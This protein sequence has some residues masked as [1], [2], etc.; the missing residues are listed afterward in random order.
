MTQASVHPR[1][2]L[3]TFSFLL[4]ATAAMFAYGSIVHAFRTHNVISY[5]RFWPCELCSDEMLRVENPH[6]HPNHCWNF[7]DHPGTSSWYPNPL[8]TSY[9]PR[10]KMSGVEMPY[11]TSTSFVYLVLG[12]CLVY[13]TRRKEE[14]A[15]ACMDIG[16]LVISLAWVAASSAVFHTESTNENRHTDWR[17]IS[18]LLAWIGATCLKIDRIEWQPVNFHVDWIQVDL[19]VKTACV[20]PAIYIGLYLPQFSVYVGASIFGAGYIVFMARELKT[21]TQGN[22]TSVVID[23]IMA[24][25]F[26]FTSLVCKSYGSEPNTMG[27]ASSIFPNTQLHHLAECTNNVVAARIEDISHGWWH[28]HSAYALWFVMLPLF[29]IRPLAD[30]E[31]VYALVATGAVA[32]LVYAEMAT[33]VDARVYHAWIGMTYAYLLTLS[34]IL[35]AYGNYTYRSYKQLS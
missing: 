26:G 1:W 24:G 30:H 6:H 14:T 18:P 34:M 4:V 33:S 25:L 9:P 8:N 22:R 7:F 19:L 16:G 29:G 10:Y 2:I 28:V 3:K 23:A 12:G 20:F 31:G 15:E 13:L 32:F 5:H 27:P 21:P 11:S 35:V 17:M